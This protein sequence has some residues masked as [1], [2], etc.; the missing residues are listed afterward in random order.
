MNDGQ[1]CRE[2]DPRAEK[3]VGGREGEQS[4][5]GENQ[6]GGRAGEEEG[7]EEAYEEGGASGRGTGC[8]HGPSQ[9]LARR[10]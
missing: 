9:H 4:A 3:R 7:G 10:Q 8:V 5:R 2:Q 1:A 6:E